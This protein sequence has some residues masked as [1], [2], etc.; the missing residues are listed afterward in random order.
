MISFTLLIAFHTRTLIYSDTWIKSN[1]IKVNPNTSVTEFY[2]KP[3]LETSKTP[4]IDSS[5]KKLYFISVDLLSI[6]TK[7]D[8][9]ADLKNRKGIII[10]SRVHPGETSSSWMVQ[11]LIN[12]LIGDSTEAKFIRDNYVVK[13]IPMLN[14]DGV[15]VGNHR[16]NI[17]GKKI[18]SSSVHNLLILGYDLNRQWNM[19]MKSQSA[20]K[21]APEIWYTKDLAI[22]YS[23]IRKISLYCDIHGHK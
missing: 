19:S 11:E 15:I 10:T 21:M 23:S 14:P 3:S 9:P 6:T 1:E 12:F 4:A 16:C 7:V 20:K 2:A 5:L 13:I 22:K 18:S 17:K 8:T